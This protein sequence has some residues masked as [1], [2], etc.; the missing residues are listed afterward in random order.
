MVRALVGLQLL[1]SS[2]V[3]AAAELP[4]HTAILVDKKKH[5]LHIARYK[6]TGYE[7]LKTFHTVIGK[8]AGDK[9]DQGDLKTPE[10]VYDF[11]ARLTPPSLKPK[12]GEMAFYIEYPNAFDQMAGQTGYDIML[13]AT[14]TPDRLEKNFDSEGCVVVRNE[15]IRQIMP[16]IRLGL[17]PILIFGDLSPDYMNPTGDSKL[18][19]FF[20]NWIA[21]WEGK[22]IDQYIGSY[23]SAFRAEG[24][25]LPE[26]KAHKARLNDLYAKIEVN[27]SDVQ[28]YRHPKY[29]VIKFI[30]NYR[31]QLKG[32][33]MGHTSAGTKT[34]IIGEEDG[35]MKIISED[36][37]NLRW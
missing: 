21:A 17:T 3:F 18:V 20:N 33:A 9:L 7:I 13:H 19:Q 28:Y 4:T 27:P 23:H 5:E 35:E 36:Y 8:V 15:D 1:I 25:S 14:D 34:I 2:A 11:R 16:Y 6:E 30:Q 26:Y 10:G 12:F 37:S 31:S 22:K 24:K 29:S 32:G